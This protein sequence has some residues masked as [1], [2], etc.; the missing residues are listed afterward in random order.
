MGFL[1]L[2]VVVNGYSNLRADCCG[3]RMLQK[4]LWV[5]LLYDASFGF[6]ERATQEFHAYVELPLGSAV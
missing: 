1:L 4:F 3:I 5:A 6:S 2:K